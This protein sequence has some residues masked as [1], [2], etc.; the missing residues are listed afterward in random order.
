[1]RA[2]SWSKNALALPHLPL[3][4]STSLNR[5]DTAIFDLVLPDIFSFPPAG[6]KLKICLA[7]KL[8]RIP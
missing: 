8:N 4:F 6:A 2:F 7:L 5:T 1:M 3:D